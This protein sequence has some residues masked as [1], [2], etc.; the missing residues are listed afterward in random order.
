MASDD[1]FGPD[2][3]A[4]RAWLDKRATYAA[5]RD[6][7][8]PPVPQRVAE[9]TGGPAATPV[10]AEPTPRL[11]DAHDAGRSV[12]DMLGPV[13][14]DEPAAAPLSLEPLPDLEP[15]AAPAPAPAPRPFEPA[16][17]TTAARSDPAPATVR[18]VEQEADDLPPANIEFQP[19]MRTR[20]VLSAVLLAVLA[21]TAAAITWAVR[22]PTAGTIGVAAVLGLLLLVVW[23]VRATTY[24]ARL[25]I[26]RGQLE[27]ARGGRRWIV[28]LANPYTP[29]A[30]VGRPERRGWQVLIEQVDAPLLTLTA[31]DVDPEPFMRVLLRLRPDL[32]P[33]AGGGHG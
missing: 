23:A 19:R 22:Q 4:I 5:D 27:V 13:V 31:T 20:R 24:P 14:V 15:E 16:R 29:V 2:T 10:R 21:A 18:W 7:P 17:R 12:V 1:E 33:R 25:T 9:R 8:L 32:R 3:S 30:V 11:P 6:V 28:D 26:R